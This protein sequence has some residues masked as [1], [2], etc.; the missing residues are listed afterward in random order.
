MLTLESEEFKIAKETYKSKLL[1]ITRL[2]DLKTNNS[3]IIYGCEIK[4]ALKSGDG[5]PSENTFV[6]DLIVYP[7]LRSVEELL[8]FI[9]NKYT[10]LYDFRINTIY[11]LHDNSSPMKIIINI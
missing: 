8:L 4:Y 9:M 5:R 11:I 6:N 3:W 7:V 1:E 10:N 2:L